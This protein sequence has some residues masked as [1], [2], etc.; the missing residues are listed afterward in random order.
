MNYGYQNE[1]NFVE[2]FNNK[3]LK[4]LDENSKKFI[5]ELFFNIIDDDEQIKCWK[6]KGLKKTDIYIK[7]KNYVKGVSL[8]CGKDNSVHNENIQN[9]KRF[10]EHLNIPYKVIDYYASYHYGY[11]KDENGK[12]DYSKL[13]S[14]NEYKELYQNQLDEFNKYIN[15]TKIIV[16]MIDRYIVRGTNSDYDIDA[17]ISGRVNNYV[18]L[19]KYDIYD[20]ILSK[21]CLNF[22]SPHVACLTI[23]PK[24]RNLNHSSTHPQ[25]RYLV[26]VIWNYIREDIEN[27]KK[28]NNL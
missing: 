17:F 10:L 9:F 28:A 22:T 1:Y 13:L 20:L 12:N 2:L 15:K 8:K 5:K 4:E 18:W 21:R 3:F 11:K 27:F 6:D 26:C 19:M 25:D 23:G 7:Y 16:E 14:G 24:K